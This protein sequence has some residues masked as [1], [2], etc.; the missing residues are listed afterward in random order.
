VTFKLGRLFFNAEAPDIPQ[1]PWI[2]LSD[3]AQDA[4]AVVLVNLSTKPSFAGSTT[5]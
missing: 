4:T 3:P 1:H 2:L 5:S